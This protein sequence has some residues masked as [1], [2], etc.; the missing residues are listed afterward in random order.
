MQEQ[1]K[2]I[3][4]KVVTAK[5][6]I[7]NRMGLLYKTVLVK[8]DRASKIRRLKYLYASLGELLAHLEMQPTA[9][10]E[11]VPSDRT[12]VCAELVTMGYRLE[13]QDEANKRVEAARITA[14]KKLVALKR[15]T[16]QQLAIAEAAKKRARVAMSQVDKLSAKLAK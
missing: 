7:P 11:V 6:I 4:I 8:R 9:D 5:V 16:T 15:K 10:L 14:E 13:T 1:A 2:P 12:G 3:P